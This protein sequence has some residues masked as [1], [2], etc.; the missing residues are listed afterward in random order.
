[1]A[2]E[3]NGYLLIVFISLAIS[4]LSACPK[5]G[6]DTGS[7]GGLSPINP[8]ILTPPEPDKIK[9]AF[10]PSTE[11]EKIV[12]ST[13]ELDKLLS[14]RLGIP[15]ESVV[16]PHYVAAVEALGTGDCLVGWLPP[17]AYIYAHDRHDA[18]MALKAVR[19]GSANYF[20]QIIV[21]A[22]SPYKTLAD[23]RGAKFAFV[24]P[25]STSGYLYPRAMLKQA[26]IDPDKDLGGS[27]MAGA[28]D[29][30]VIA[31]LQG[32][33][34][35]GA[36]YVDARE[37]VLSINSKVMEETRVIAKT[38]A[39]PGDS[40]VLAGERYLTDEWAK[41]ITDAL[42]AVAHSP[43]GKATIMEIYDIEDLLPAT[44]ADYDPVRKMAT[45]L[46]LDVEKELGK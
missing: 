37:K 18:R 10:V 45:S 24:D 46:G 27:I 8:V 21:R 44:D 38:D 1:M 29:A 41:K 25:N 20:G 3:R 26:G 39:I 28:H 11:A 23:I 30:V 43:E 22:E 32:S 34:D 35:A 19:K 6:S 36:C 42:I 40:V 17:L 7:E 33:V 12:D 15:V 16:L 14:D 4:A 9:M 5:R 2:F 31:V 13:K